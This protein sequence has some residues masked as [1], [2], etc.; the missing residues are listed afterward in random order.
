[1]IKK[2][3]MILYLAS[4][5]AYGADFFTTSQVLNKAYLDLS[6]CTMDIDHAYIHRGYHFKAT[7]Y[8]SDTDSGQ[9]KFWLFYTTTTA[10]DINM[11]YEFA[12]SLNGT[13]KV[14]EGAVIASTGTAVTSFNSKRSSTNVAHGKL[15]YD[16]V[17]TSSGTL[18]DVRVVG[19]DGTN[20]TGRAGGS[21]T[22]AYEFIV[23]PN[24]KYLFEFTSLSDNNRSCL[25]LYYYEEE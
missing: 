14:Y 7:D 16:P 11:C 4:S 5:I 25:R 19:S 3:L 21:V 9:S 15:S 22:R 2:I 12:A 24:I 1:M 20:P 17:F 23:M 6:L 8:D 13:L 10:Y 18:I